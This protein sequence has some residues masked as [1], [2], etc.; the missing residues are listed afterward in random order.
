MVWFARTQ[1]RISRAEGAV[2][3]LAYALYIVW[4]VVNA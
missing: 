2:M 1:A 3:M 4:L